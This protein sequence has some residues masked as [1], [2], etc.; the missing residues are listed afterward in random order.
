MKNVITAII[1][2]TFSLGVASEVRAASCTEIAKSVVNQVIAVSGDSVAT[3]SQKEGYDDLI[4]VHTKICE[5]G[6][7]MRKENASYY[8]ATRLIRGASAIGSKG[9]V[10]KNRFVSN[11]ISNMS[12]SMGYTYGE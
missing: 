11:A 8:D 1:I 9:G 4:H 3:A 5:N 12:F 2:A 6:V 10:D 7:R